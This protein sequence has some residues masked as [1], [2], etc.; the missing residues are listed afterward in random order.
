MLHFCVPPPPRPPQP[1]QKPIEEALNTAKATLSAVLPDKD[2]DKKSSRA[3]SPEPDAHKSTSAYLEAQYKRFS[4]KLFHGKEAP[5]GSPSPPASGPKPG[6]A[7]ASLQATLPLGVDVTDINPLAKPSE[8]GPPP[9]RMIILLLGL[10]PHRAGIWTSSARPSESVIHYLLFN[11]C[12]TIVVPV[13]PGSPL[14][15]WDTL[16]LT[17]L[18]KYVKEGR[19]NDGIIRILFEYVSLCVDWDRVIL[20]TGGETDNGVTEAEVKETAVEGLPADESGE[21]GASSADEEKKKKSLK[22]ALELL[23]TATMKTVDSKEVEDKV[24]PDRA[25]VAF[26]RLP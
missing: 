8:A 26:F 15:A 4:N 20:P 18:Q 7:S 23:I 25:G 6:E 17:Q 13:K 19:R 12:P 9:R 11:G 16:T 22:D 5:A 24:D 14:V 3:P 10:K 21:T 1:E 2:K